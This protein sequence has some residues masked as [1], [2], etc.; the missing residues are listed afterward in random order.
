M[1]TYA[2]PLAFALVITTWAALI[3]IGCALVFWPH[4]TAGFVAAP[5]LSPDSGFFDAFN[6]SLASLTNFSSDSFAKE[7]WLRLVMGL[8]GVVGFGLLTASVSWLLSLYPVLEL[9]RSLA[10][11]ATLLHWAELEN[12]I[13]AVQLPSGE[14]QSILDRLTAQLT[15]L[16][17]QLAQFPITY[18]FHI[19]EEQTALSGV[20][21]YLAE[22]G[23]RA[24]R[25]GH[26]ASVRLAGTALG[27]A[28]DS[29]LELIATDFLRMPAH[30]K[31]AILRRHAS[32]QLRDMVR[33]TKGRRAA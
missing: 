1:I 25:P 12:D 27:G 8:E 20:L 23:L 3:V 22:L 28:V 11:Q 2:G 17:N 19:G 7:K 10:Q 4:M 33:T 32:D 24:S 13:D 31:A 21:S 5:G 30:D 26:A 16:R 29:Y 18:Y 14:A 9:R 15:T 6:T